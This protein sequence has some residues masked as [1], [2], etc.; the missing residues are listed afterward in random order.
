MA[1]TEAQ[2]TNMGFPAG[3]LTTS[4][5]IYFTAALEWLNEN[6]DFELDTEDPEESVSALP[7]SAKIFITKYI[8]ML[9][10]GGLS[11]SIVTSESIGGMSK[12]YGSSTESGKALWLL[13]RELLGSHLIRGVIK[14]TG[15]YSKWA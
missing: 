14:F 8:G 9:Q 4:D 11:G 12:S 10:N 13:A 15:E 1:L 7:A 3:S 2:I 5:S 6:T